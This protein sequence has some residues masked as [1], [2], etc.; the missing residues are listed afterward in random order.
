M[1]DPSEYN[2]PVSGYGTDFPGKSI[3]NAGD[4]PDEPGNFQT[5][6]SG[7]A[8]GVAGRQLV[9]PFK[10]VVGLDGERIGLVEEVP[11]GVRLDRCRPPLVHHVG[12]RR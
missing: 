6:R 4:A 8:A 1:A 11:N 9:A 5:E 3:E 7:W 10:P 12:N 2:P